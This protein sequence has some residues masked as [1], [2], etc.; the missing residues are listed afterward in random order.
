M[1]SRKGANHS[2]G[3]RLRSTPARSRTACTQGRRR[4]RSPMRG[5]AAPGGRYRTNRRRRLHWRK[6]RAGR[7]HGRQRHLPRHRCSGLQIAEAGKVPIG[8]GGTAEHGQ[9]IALC[10]QAGTDAT[11]HLFGA[12][13][14]LPFSDGTMQVVGCLSDWLHRT[15]SLA[16]VTPRPVQPLIFNALCSCRIFCGYA[17]IVGDKAAV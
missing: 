5:V 3:C 17:K 6:C 14:L 13:T 4:A 15:R 10:Q 8:L 11:L 2:G 12:Q 9:L 7:R 1:G 16:L